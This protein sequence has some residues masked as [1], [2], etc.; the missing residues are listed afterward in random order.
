MSEILENL[1]GS[2]S[3]TRLLRFFMQNPEQEYLQ[4]EIAKRNMLNSWLS[5]KNWIIW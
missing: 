1:F 5:G 3:K 2:K 4:S